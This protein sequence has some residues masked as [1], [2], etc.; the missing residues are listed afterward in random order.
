MCTGYQSSACGGVRLYFTDPTTTQVAG[1]CSTRATEFDGNG[2]RISSSTLCASGATP[3]T[4][5]L[6][7][8]ATS[9]TVQVRRPRVRRTHCSLGDCT[10]QKAAG[11]CTALACLG[12]L[13]AAP[14]SLSVVAAV[15]TP[16]TRQI[17]RVV[18]GWQ[19]GREG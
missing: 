17:N 9:D 14:R 12:L 10:W 2:L 8:S 19:A 18:Y 15:S 3:D 6:T 5:T 13:A 4:F 7:T 16:P 11:K 1:G